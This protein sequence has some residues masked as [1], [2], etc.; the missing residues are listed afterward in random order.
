MSTI[1]MLNLKHFPFDNEGDAIKTRVL[2][3]ALEPRPEEAE[4]LLRVLDESLAFAARYSAAK[5]EVDAGN[6]LVK[7]FSPL[8]VEEFRAHQAERFRFEERHGMDRGAGRPMRYPGGP[9]RPNLFAPADGLGNEL[10]VAPA[11]TDISQMLSDLG[12]AN[13]RAAAQ[14]SALRD[15]VDPQ[16]LTTWR[17]ALHDAAALLVRT[18]KAQLW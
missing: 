18:G 1:P 2:L 6:S 3:T 15:G 7:A 16:V 17:R 9:Q 12:S 14:L 4:A 8:G 5:T 11:A 10:G 13:A